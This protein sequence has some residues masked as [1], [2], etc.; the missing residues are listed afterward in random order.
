[1]ELSLAETRT[2]ALAV[3]NYDY[4]AQSRT[5]MFHDLTWWGE[6]LNAARK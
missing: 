4:L 2:G 5:A 6:A 3:N 1:M